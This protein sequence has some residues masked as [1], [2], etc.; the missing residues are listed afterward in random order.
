MG[1]HNGDSPGCLDRQWGCCE[2]VAAAK[3]TGRDQLMLLLRYYIYISTVIIIN[4]YS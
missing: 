1:V 2:A 3:T 4:Y